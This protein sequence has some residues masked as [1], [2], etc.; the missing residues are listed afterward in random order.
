MKKKI[1][2]FEDKKELKIFENELKNKMSLF[3]TFG[4]YLLI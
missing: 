1:E 2:E 4:K 3:F